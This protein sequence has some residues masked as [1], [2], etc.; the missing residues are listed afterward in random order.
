MSTPKILVNE[1]NRVSMRNDS[2][3]VLMFS[4]KTLVA[5]QDTDGRTYRTSKFY[6]KTTSMH[7]SAFGVKECQQIDQ[8][9]LEGMV[10]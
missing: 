9:T 7:L 2:G 6:S 10:K 8:A 5:L 1:S 4:Y 3:Q